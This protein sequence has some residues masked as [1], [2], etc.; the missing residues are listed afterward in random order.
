MPCFS[1][2]MTWV[3]GWAPRCGDS[4]PIPSGFFPSCFGG[5]AMFVVGYAIAL[6]VFPHG[7]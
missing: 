3:S 7:K 4:S 2:P 6:V 5:A 1:S